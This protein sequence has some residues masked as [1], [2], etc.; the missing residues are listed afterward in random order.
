MSFLCAS[1]TNFHL[2]FESVVLGFNLFQQM[3]F[4]DDL[5]ARD[6]DYSEVP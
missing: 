5:I 1:K 6:F 3:R 4:K 2:S